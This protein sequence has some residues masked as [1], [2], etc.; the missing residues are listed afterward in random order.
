[1]IRHVIP[2]ILAAVS[3]T[4]MPLVAAA[5]AGAAAGWSAA[6]RSDVTHVPATP[7]AGVHLRWHPRESLHIGRGALASAVVGG[8]IYA[9][10]G[11]TSGQASALA[12]AEVY[13][14]SVNAWHQIAPMPVATAMEGAAAVDGRVFAVGGLNTQGNPIAVVQAYD[15]V[16]KLWRQEAPLPVPI[17]MVAVAAHGGRIYAVGGVDRSGSF[18]AGLEIYNPTANTWTQGPPMPTARGLAQ[19]TWADGQLYVIGGVVA[20][21]EARTGAVEAYNPKTNTWETRATLPI[22]RAHP[23]VATVC[24][25]IIVA[26]GGVAS[27]QNLADVEVYDPAANTWRKAT[28][29]KHGDSGGTTGAVDD[30]DE[31]YVIGGFEGP[32]VNA[33]KTV[34]SATVK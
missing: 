6:D 16:T 23:A 33:G 9:L 12:V 14:P 15:P 5:P 8:E 28:P 11:F 30:H 3:L 10:G 26:G 27:H 34:Q 31:F 18:V 2:G 19:A 21:S 7:L 1:M 29:L 20:P 25:Q 13:D 17:G 24:G 22:P 32:D 4:A